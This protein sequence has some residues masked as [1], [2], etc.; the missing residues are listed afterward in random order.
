MLK[1][2]CT[3]C[4]G[5]TNYSSSKPKFCSSC[6]SPFDKLVVNKTLNQKQTVDTPIQ[7]RRILPKIQPKARV[8]DYEN[9]NDSDEYDDQDVNYVPEVKGLEVELNQI[10]PQKTKI[11][12][13]IGSAKSGGTREKITAKKLT[14]SEKKK[15]FEDFQREA[16]SLRPKSRG[17]KDG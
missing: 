16:G 5:P 4:G 17:R 3:E 2:Y 1:I 12:D 9:D 7:Q 10:Q 8:E 6:G 15:F 13:I 14:K 11:G